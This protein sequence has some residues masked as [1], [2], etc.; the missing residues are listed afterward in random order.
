MRLRDVM[1]GLAAAGLPDGP[2]ADVEIAALAYDDRKVRPGTLFFCVPGFSRDGHDFAPAAVAAGAA[3]L[4]VERPLGLGVPEVVVESVRAAMAPAAARFHED[5]TAALDVVAITGTNGKTTTAFLVRTLLEAAGRQCGLLGTVTSFVGGRE[6]PVERTTAEAIELQRD[7]R[8]MVDGGDVA[9][10]M[11]ISSHALELH[12]ADAIHVAAAVFTNLTQDH[13]DFHP[14]M[15]DY[16][17][18]KRRLFEMGP[19]VAIVNVD[20]PYG[21]RLA[22]ALEHEGPLVTYAIEVTRWLAV[23]LCFVLARVFESGARMREEL[24]GTV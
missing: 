14:T 7:V 16:F 11:E 15:E 21:R 23:L 10:A 9:C 2:G 5:P 12:R 20:D 4:V 8:A 3:A 1:G 6:R 18:A 17:A 19:A 22:T 13:L 24:A